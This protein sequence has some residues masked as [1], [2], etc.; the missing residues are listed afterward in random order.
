MGPISWDHS[1]ALWLSPQT[2][3][4]RAAQ[5]SLPGT[6]KSQQLT[7][8]GIWAT[9]RDGGEWLQVEEGGTA[10]DG[11]LTLKTQASEWGPGLNSR[12]A[13]QREPAGHGHRAHENLVRVEGKG[14]P[15]GRNPLTGQLDAA[16]QEGLFTSPVSIARLPSLPAST[17]TLQLQHQ[18]WGLLFI[19]SHSPFPDPGETCGPG[20]PESPQSKTFSCPRRRTLGEPAG[21][22]CFQHQG[23]TLGKSRATESTRAFPPLQTASPFQALPRSYS[24]KRP[25]GRPGM[26]TEK[27][28]SCL[29]FPSP[30]SPSL[31]SGRHRKAADSRR[32][33]Y[34]EY[35]E[36][37]DGR[38]SLA[39]KSSVTPHC[40]RKTEDT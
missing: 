24:S 23:T 18:K 15:Q 3:W 12:D 32:T 7:L 37:I 33:T 8:A 31:S 20:E 4:L 38:V 22:G 26:L 39:R 2:H 30:A 1:P 28:Q 35:R 16:K 25:C 40:P 36:P 27:A 17:L 21:A 11:P 6:A 9:G 19:P 14:T 5:A 34:T 13:L 10:L 29:Y